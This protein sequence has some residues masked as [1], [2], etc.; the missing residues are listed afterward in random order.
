MKVVV[1]MNV[2]FSFFKSDSP[3]RKLLIT[4]D[5]VK[6]HTPSLC[7]KELLAHREEICAKAGISVDAFRVLLAD[8]LLYVDVVDE[9]CFK[10]CAPEAAKMLSGHVKDVPYVALALYFS[11]EGHSCVVCR[12]FTGP[13]VSFNVF[14]CLFQRTRIPFGS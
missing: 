2:L 4:S 1:D 8:L 11:K 9:G 12:I 5:G 10:D 13:D 6:F 7:I 14:F 3:K